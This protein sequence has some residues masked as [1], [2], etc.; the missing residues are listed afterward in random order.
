MV[1]VPLPGIRL[2][3]LPVR[4]VHWSFVVLLAAMWWTGEEGDLE[5]HKQLGMVFLALLAFRLIWGV[6]GSETAR[7]TQF[8]KGPGTVFAYLKRNKA[9]AAPIGHSPLGGLSVL[10]LLFL[11]SLQIGLGL[12]AQDVDGIES[13]PLSHLVS[14]ETSDAARE[15][16]E[17][18]FNIILGFVAL[19]VAA[20][21]FY[22]FARRDN[23]IMPMISGRKVMNDVAQPRSGSLIA[24]LSCAAIA[25]ALMWWIWLGA[26]PTGQ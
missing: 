19:H 18:I 3:D 9:G 22:L 2:W 5:L 25:C 17:L 24:F 13:G 16:H 26:P 10:A 12:I 14:Y 21:L 20:I 1:E 8:V 23:L 4:I 15:W 7:F 6:F 11:L